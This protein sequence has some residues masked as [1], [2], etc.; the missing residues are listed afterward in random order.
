MS[1]EGLIKLDH[2][3]KLA[4]QEFAEHL[5]ITQRLV[6]LQISSVC[7]G[8]AHHWNAQNWRKNRYFTLI[9]LFWERQRQ[10]KQGRSRKREGERIPSRLCT[11]STEPHAGLELKKLGDHDLSQNQ[12]WTLNW[13]SHSGAPNCYYWIVRVGLTWL[14]LLTAV[15]LIFVKCLLLLLFFIF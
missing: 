5:D 3:P 7:T 1:Y 2:K 11:V 12:G 15:T 14:Q 6:T 8:Y 4:H 9:Y 10:Y 13:L